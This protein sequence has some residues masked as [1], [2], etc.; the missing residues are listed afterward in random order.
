MFLSVLFGCQNL[1]NLGENENY[2]FR[3]WKKIELSIAQDMVFGV[4]GGKKMSPK[5]LGLA[6]TLHQKTRSKDH[7][8]DFYN[9]GHCLSYDKLLKVDATLANDTLV[10]LDENTGAVIPQ[11]LVPGGGLI[12]FTADNTDIKDCGPLNGKNIFNACGM[13]AC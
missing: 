1:S 3:K 6:S 5:H 13:I 10:S 8:N 7:V 9:A 11:N 4:S 2:E 12:Q